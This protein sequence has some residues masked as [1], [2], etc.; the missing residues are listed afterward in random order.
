M[1][2]SPMR[3]ADYDIHIV[4]IDTGTVGAVN[5]AAGA[6]R[7]I[8]QSSQLARSVAR[9]NAHHAIYL[10]HL[11]TLGSPAF[12]QPIFFFLCALP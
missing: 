7:R 3:C 1:I 5:I 4:D 10:A 9:R 8:Y 11:R 12:D 6:S 2:T